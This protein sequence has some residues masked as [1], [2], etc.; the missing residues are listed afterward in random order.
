MVVKDLLLMI[1]LDQGSLNRGVVLE[2]WIQI[3]QPESLSILDPK[4]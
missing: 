1:T 3:W 2:E 4:Y